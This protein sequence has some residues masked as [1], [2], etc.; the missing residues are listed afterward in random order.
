MSESEPGKVKC[1]KCG[2]DVDVIDAEYA[3]HYVVANVVCT[4]SRRE[5]REEAND[6]HV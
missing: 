5:V 3:R 4:M 6:N 2:Q 1:P